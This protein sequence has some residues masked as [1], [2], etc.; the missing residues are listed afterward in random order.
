MMKHLKNFF[1]PD[2]LI[3]TY[4]QSKAAVLT[5]IEDVLNRKVTFWGDRDMKGHFFR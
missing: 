3:F 5:K 4:D 2:T 1:F